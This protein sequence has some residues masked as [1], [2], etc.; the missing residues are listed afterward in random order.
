MTAQVASSTNIAWWHRISAPTGIRPVFS[1][2]RDDNPV[3]VASLILFEFTPEAAVAAIENMKVPVKG[4]VPDEISV[5]AAFNA[6]FAKIGRGRHRR[7]LNTERLIRKYFGDCWLATR[8]AFFQN[9][10]PGQLPSHMDRP[11]LLD[12]H[13]ARE[14]PLAWTILNAVDRDDDVCWWLDKIAE[15]ANEDD[16]ALVVVLLLAYAS[17]ATISACLPLLS[18]KV[19]S[20][21]PDRLMA[22]YELL[23]W[24]GLRRPRLNM[25][26]IDVASCCAAARALLGLRSRVDQR[27]RV[28]DEASADLLD[29]RF[30]S[31]VSD[32]IVQTI[33]ARMRHTGRWMGSQEVAVRH[34]RFSQL[35][36]LATDYVYATAYETRELEDPII[37]EILGKPSLYPSELVRMADSD[38]LRRL[39]S[40]ATPI[41]VTAVQDA[42]FEEPQ[43][44]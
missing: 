23:R 27:V 32:T 7:T 36:A 37:Q 19:S 40:H 5:L 16:S 35:G 30:R 14:R 33:Q 12:G 21:S 3:D 22:V 9:V 42:W 34:A 29:T 28:L 44:F 6:E 38:G 2:W 4:S 11:A 1:A 15:I 20:W 10:V 41:A 18:E 26:K 43:P 13:A 39:A 31:Q 24:A 17:E 8:F 25:A